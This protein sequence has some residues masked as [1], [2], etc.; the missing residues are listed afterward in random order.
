MPKGAIYLPLAAADVL[1]YLVTRPKKKAP[2]PAGQ[3][4][5]QPQL[6]MGLP[7]G[8]ANPSGQPLNDVLALFTNPMRTDPYSTF[9][10]PAP[11]DA[12]SPNPLAPFYA[13]TLDAG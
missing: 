8:P 13:T 9:A 4:H 5:V 10:A 1:V 2:A 6:D 12:V 11:M 3:T 7:L